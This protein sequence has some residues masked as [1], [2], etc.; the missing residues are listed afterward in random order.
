MYNDDKG[1]R[2]MALSITHYAYRNTPIEDFHADDVKMDK[3][4]Y[5]KVYNI[6]RRKL[7]NVC[8]LQCYLDD[9][10]CEKIEDIDDKRK[11]DELLNSVPKALQLKFIRYMQHII[12][13][14]LYGANWDAACQVEGIK[15]GQSHA[16]YV[17]GGEFSKCCKNGNILNDSTMCDLNK[18][19]HNRIYTLLINGYF[20][21]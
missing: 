19:V 7:Q 2:I 17:L 9:F 13:G 12:F 5:R 1:R 21:K 3:E 8:L 6:V 14:R 15:E 20:Y 18:D 10:P 16:S 11:F 4:L